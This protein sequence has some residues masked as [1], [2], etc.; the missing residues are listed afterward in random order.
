MEDNPMKILIIE[1]DL[2]D[3]NK[4]KNC[5][6]NRNDIEIVAITDSDIEALQLVKVKHP[7]GIVLDLELNKGTSG[8][9]D[10]LEFLNKLKELNLKY[11]PIVIVTTHISS[12]RTYEVLHKNGAELILYKDHPRYSQNHVLNSFITL[13]KSSDK[14]STNI[15]E[16][17]ENEEEKILNLIDSE[18]NLIGIAPKMVGREYVKDAILY[19]IQNDEDKINV[20]Q[21]LINKYKKSS[22]TITNGI[23]NA[24]NYAW[25]ISPTEDLEKYYKARINY[26]TGVPTPMEFIYYYVEKIK[27]EL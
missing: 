22:T 24:I 17:L 23:Q 6:K 25:R 8:S 21:Y 16:T 12:R 3:C 7:E 20:I 13:R 18:L 14:D 11:E 10:S 5:V 2:D 26:T 27:K 1:D 19:L 15:Q 4:F 9:T